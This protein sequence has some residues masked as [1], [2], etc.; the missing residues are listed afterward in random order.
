LITQQQGDQIGRF[1]ANWD[2]FKVSKW[3]KNV[4]D[5]LG[6][7]IKLRFRYFWPFLTWQLFGRFFEKFGNFFSNLLVTLLSNH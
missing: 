1:F 4:V 2:T 6:F 7:Q 5:V 3:F